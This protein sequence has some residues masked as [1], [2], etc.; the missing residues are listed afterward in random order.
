MQL[1]VTHK[2]IG[3]LCREWYG[4][5]DVIEVRSSAALHEHAD[6]EWAPHPP[7]SAS[8]AEQSARAALA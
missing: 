4:I 3:Q 2:Q 7:G 8:I 6:G 1:D 5:V